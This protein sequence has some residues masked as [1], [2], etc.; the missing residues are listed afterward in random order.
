MFFVVL[1][2]SSDIRR[3]EQGDGSGGQKEK[4]GGEER[5]GG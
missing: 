3:M 5:V 4:Y 1:Y 2:S